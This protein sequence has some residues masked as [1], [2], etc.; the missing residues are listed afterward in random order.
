MSSNN[1]MTVSMLAKELDA[2]QAAVRYI[3][4][5][6]SPWLEYVVENEQ[7]L[8]NDDALKTLFFIWEKINTGMIPSEI[9]TAL[10][11]KNSYFLKKMTAGK[12]AEPYSTS[13]RLT[14]DVI[15]ILSTFVHNLEKHQERI[16]RVEERKAEAEE[17][18]AYAMIRHAEAEEQK[19]YALGNLT[20]ALNNLE[21]GFFQN[22][23]V[24]TVSPEKIKPP[25]QDNNKN[26][27]Q[28]KDL[29]YKGKS[30]SGMN[31]LS[32]LI[33]DEN[34]VHHGD[35][36]S[37]NLSDLL[38]LI[39]EDF[40]Q[41]ETVVV[42]PDIDDLS[43]LI[44]DP[45]SPG[46]DETASPLNEMDDLDS[47]IDDS[48]EP[49]IE[50]DTPD[51]DDLSLLIDDKSPSSSDKTASIPDDM[52]DLSLLIDYSSPPE[53]DAA[54]PDMDDLSLLIDDKSPSSSD[55]TASIPDDMDDLS[56]LIE[57]DLSMDQV[58]PENKESLSGKLTPGKN[59]K[60]IPD[61][62]K[63]KVTPKENFKKYKA[64]IINL[65]IKLKSD[66][67]SV[68]ETTQMFNTEDIQT[69]SGKNK[70]NEKMI[71]QIYKF[72]ESAGK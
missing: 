66:G 8:Y 7:K 46:T 50:A 47:F 6:F 45:S 16:A 65:I 44:D 24:E 38:N 52:D 20:N 30:P 55:K 25:H 2:G 51:M 62:L 43:L 42:E 18:K 31:G 59:K 12:A 41:D 36:G 54:P 15:K 4:N 28:D 48:S 70:W 34:L 61:K 29:E 39:D 21:N 53:T 69:L 58:Q 13:E 11:T 17:K 60:Q 72:I 32:S 26:S 68:E 22:K 37:N 10:D 35:D 1:L 64:Q 14:P 67:H 63:P 5:R 33:D 3:L 19:A 71:A 9:E 27:R 56:L 57:D 49:G 23:A 40:P